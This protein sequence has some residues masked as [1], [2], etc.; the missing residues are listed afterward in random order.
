MRAPSEELRALAAGLVSLPAD[1]PERVEAYRRARGDDQLR[2]AL[3]EGERLMEL[4]ALAPESPTE[5][6]QSAA[7]EASQEIDARQA[8][9]WRSRWWPRPAFSRSSN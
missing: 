2:R 4:L 8:R 7:A 3:R 1:D 9:R 6:R 5:A